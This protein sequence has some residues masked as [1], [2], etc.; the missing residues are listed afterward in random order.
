MIVLWRLQPNQR[1]GQR[2]WYEMHVF[3]CKCNARQERWRGVL[4]MPFARWD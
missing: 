4:M 1:L 3:V 2:F